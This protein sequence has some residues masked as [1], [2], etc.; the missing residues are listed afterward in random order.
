MI[1][2]SL[3]RVT[4]FR[5]RFRALFALRVHED[6]APL[7]RPRPRALEPTTP[8]DV[9]H[10]I[11]HRL[12]RPIVFNDTR[13]HD[14]V[15][16]RRRH[17]ARARAPSLEP[18]TEETFLTLLTLFPRRA[19]PTSADRRASQRARDST[20]RRAAAARARRRRDSRP[21][22]SVRRLGVSRRRIETV[23]ASPSSTI[24]DA[25]ASHDAFRDATRVERRARDVRVVPRRLSSRARVRT[26]RRCN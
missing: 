1:R 19:R 26:R 24:G 7:K 16:R 21:R 18:R 8:D 20:A 2:I 15:P 14:D 5:I 25:R 3:H 22:R 10:P 11:S 23:E 9:R 4:S 17:P 6:D 12:A 13:A